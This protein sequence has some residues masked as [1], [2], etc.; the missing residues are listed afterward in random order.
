L[1]VL[2]HKTTGEQEKYQV[3]VLL[4]H[5]CNIL[6]HTVLKFNWSHGD[7]KPRK[8]YC[9]GTGPRRPTVL[10][11]LGDLGGFIFQRRTFGGHGEP[12]FRSRTY[13]ELISKEDFW[14][15]YRTLGVVKNMLGASFSKEGLLE[16][17][18][19]LGPEVAPNYL[20]LK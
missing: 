6:Y 16:D 12:I 1:N 3:K 8:Y 4:Y 9:H 20:Y 2:L 18:L 17:I 7:S 5:N 15:L 14:A 10:E 19:Q 11:D 13:G